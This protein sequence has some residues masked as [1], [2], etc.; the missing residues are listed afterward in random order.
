[1]VG[2][3]CGQVLQREL[4]PAVIDRFGGTPFQFIGDLEIARSVQL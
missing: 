4:C 1:M 2:H 3:V